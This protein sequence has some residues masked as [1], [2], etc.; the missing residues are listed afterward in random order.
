MSHKRLYWQIPFLLFLV[1]ATVYIV[2][3]RHTQPY[4]H[5]EG[6]I[7]GTTYH[8]TYQYAG[9]LHPLLRAEM[10]RVDRSLSPFNPHSLI[11]AINEGRDTL[12][13]DL[14]C[15]VFSLAQRVSEDTGGAFDITVAPL[16]NAWGFGFRTGTPPT[17]A[18]IDSLR[19]T[20]GYRRVSLRGRRVRKADAR[21]LLDCSAIAKGYAADRV[22]RVLRDHDVANYMVEIG[23]EVATRGRNS[24]GE[25]WRIG[26]AKPTDDS[27]AHDAGALQTV[28]D[29]SDRALATSGN[30]RRFYYR[31]GRKYA[32]T[33]D[34]R[35]GYPVQHSL[36]SATVLAPSC[37]MAD[38]YATAFMVVGVDEARRILARHSELGAY[39]IYSDGG[40]T[41]TVTLP[42]R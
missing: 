41:K 28:L 17:P 35:T 22:G 16:V 1:V 10:E 12:A 38:A 42:G 3:E 24:R 15:D 19:A 31:G 9:D 7:F 25:A 33:I 11:T 37:A 2:R 34:P 23:G 13:D 5:A 20:V 27:L 8:I 29:V 39:L 6:Q 36:L 32:H 4:R 14:F 18:Q 40:K 26:V 21:T 30:Y